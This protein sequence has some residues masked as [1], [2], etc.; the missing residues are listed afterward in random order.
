MCCISKYKIIILIFV[1]TW[2]CG[3]AM[4]ENGLLFAVD[5]QTDHPYLIKSILLLGASPN[6]GEKG[7]SC[8]EWCVYY[9]HINEIN[10]LL[11]FGADPNTKF[12]LSDNCYF[13]IVEVLEKQY[14]MVKLLMKYGAN[15]YLRVNG[16]N[17]FDI[18]KD[19]KDY[20]MLHILN[21]YNSIRRD[22]VFYHGILINLIYTFIITFIC[23]KIYEKYMHG[24]LNRFSLK[25]K[26]I[27][28]C[29]GSYVV[30]GFGI[31]ATGVF[32]AS[33]PYL[34]LN[35]IVSSILYPILFFALLIIQSIVCSIFAYSV[36]EFLHTR[37]KR[38]DSGFQPQR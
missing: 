21:T 1:F 8:L 26:L 3:V 14:D 34:S 6:D 19:N 7:V 15:P 35:D 28:S 16:R 27:F 32:I 13:L 10:V 2:L 17:A 20:N 30:F 4:L 25:I 37:R 24:I 5:S 31:V 18:A 33:I 9:N 29:I 11:Q 23:Y 12:E 36:I 38:K 22:P